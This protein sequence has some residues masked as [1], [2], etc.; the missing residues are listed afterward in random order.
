MLSL[1]LS[2]NWCIRQLDVHNAFL[3]GGLA[4]DV[5]MEQLP[6]FVDPLYTTHVYKLDKSLYDLKQSPRAWYTKLSN[7]MLHLGFVTSKNDSSLFICHSFHGL[8][9]V[10]VYMDDIIVIGSHHT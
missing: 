1:A 5:F 9:L 2:H 3:L 8:L 6:G 10:F 7:S 4:E